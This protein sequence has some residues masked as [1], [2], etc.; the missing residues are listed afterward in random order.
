MARNLSRSVTQC[1]ILVNGVERNQI[2]TAL[3]VVEQVLECEM[4]KEWPERRYKQGNDDPQRKVDL[5]SQCLTH[6]KMQ[7]R[8]R[9]CA[10]Y[11]RHGNNRG[12]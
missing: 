10:K 5:D 4:R 12:R 6:R 8:R 1:V 2:A 3:V 9:I 11:A 7:I